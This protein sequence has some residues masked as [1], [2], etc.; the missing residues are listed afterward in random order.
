MKLSEVRDHCEH[1]EVEISFQEDWERPEEPKRECIIATNEG[2]YNCT[3][4][5][6]LDLI[7]YLKEN[8]PELLI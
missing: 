4:V 2:G 3:M 7:Q 5:D 6:L 1:H 8:R